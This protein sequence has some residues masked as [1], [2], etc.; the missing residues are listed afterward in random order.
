MRVAFVGDSLTVGVGDPEYLGWVGRLCAV[1]PA[2]GLALTMYNLG[3]R[4]ETS[5]HIKSRLSRELPPRL[6]P[7]DEAHVVLSFGV[8]DAKIENGRRKVELSE[9]V[10]NLF[11]IVTQVSKLCPVL[12]VGPPPVLDD[13]HRTRIEELSDVFSR[14][15]DDMGVPYLEMCRALSREAAY[16]DSLVASGDGYHPEAAGYEA[17]AAKVAAWDAWKGWLK[18]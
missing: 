11:D 13:A 2:A 18:A 6:L 7:R 5:R 14:T 9:S 16:L 17:I 12:M 3:V 10:D 1:A 4:S 15:C 8:N